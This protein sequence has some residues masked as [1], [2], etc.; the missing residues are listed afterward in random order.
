MTRQST[1]HSIH[2]APHHW[3]SRPGRKP[4]SMSLVW[5]LLSW[6]IKVWGEKNRFSANL[7]LMPYWWLSLTCFFVE[8]DEFGI[9][10]CEPED[11]HFVDTA[12]YGQAWYRFVTM[13]NLMPAPKVR[14]LIFSD[15][16]ISNF[17]LEYHKWGK[18][19]NWQRPMWN[20]HL[21]RVHLAAPPTWK[22]FRE[23]WHLADGFSKNVGRLKKK[24][25]SRSWC[26]VLVVGCW[27]IPNPPYVCS[28]KHLYQKK[29][30]S[31]SVKSGLFPTEL[32]TW[33]AGLDPI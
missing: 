18:D 31:R 14:V 6:I 10:D 23:S 2:T 9:S 17:I 8:D 16:A 3:G 4:I 12:W 26:S 7:R 32:K 21:V 30:S 27:S 20:E 15:V 22:T 33:G 5:D 19:T 24:W 28:I 13:L 29:N 25:G 1:T 11:P